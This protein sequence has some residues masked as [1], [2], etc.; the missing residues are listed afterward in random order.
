M[1]MQSINEALPENLPPERTIRVKLH[2]VEIVSS[3]ITE[4]E[5][6]RLEASVFD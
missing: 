2:S 3:N 5:N 4:T 6:L 1:S